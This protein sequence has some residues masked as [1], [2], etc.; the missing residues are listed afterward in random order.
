MSQQEQQL[1]E[2]LRNN[3][4]R[5]ISIALGSG[6]ALVGVLVIL[7]AWQLPPFTSQ[8]QS[9][10]NAYVRG[11][12]TFISP[13]VSGY[14]TAVNVLDF[15][16]VHRGDLLMK[17]D[18]RIYRQRV[19]QS[20]AQLNMKKAALANNQQ[21]R[22][23]AEAVIK[24]NQ[25]ALQ[26]AKAQALKGALDLKRVENLVADGSLSVRERDASRASNSQ[27]LAGVEQAQATLEVSRQD[28]ETTIV[29]RASLEADVANAQAALELAQID[30][31]NTKIIA[32]R[33]GQLGQIAVRQGAYVTAGTRLTSLVP[34]QMWVIANLKETQMARIRPGLP[35]SFSVDALDGER[36]NGEVEY[37]SPAAGSEFSAISP[38]NATGNFVKIAQRIPVRIK[39]TSDNA[40]RLRPGMS[41]E[42]S[43]DT[44]D[45]Q[46]GVKK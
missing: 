14:I 9:T 28:L 45:M 22:R 30:L 44:A 12:V 16:P 40:A 37:I 32:P 7:Y 11:Q 6:I 23:S 15:Q 3:K 4:L 2:R 27:M 34:Q 46:G 33:D 17:I 5:I 42:V 31:D 21:Q 18:D 20:S 39:I 29:N 10:E 43:I 41:V 25:A 35:V 1:D 13:Q 36:F 8:T 24:R 19:H 38:D 26:N